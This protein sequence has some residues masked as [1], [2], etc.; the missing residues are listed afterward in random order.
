MD[1]D[2]IFLENPDKEKIEAELE[3]FKDETVTVDLV[4][5]IPGEWEMKNSSMEYE[6][7]DTNTLVYSVLVPAKGKEKVSFTYNRRNVRN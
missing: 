7:K 2:V 6:K 1:K 4:Q 3:N 5:H